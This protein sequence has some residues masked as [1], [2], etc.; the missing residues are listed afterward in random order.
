MVEFFKLLDYVLENNV[1]IVK[2]KYLALLR[3]LTVTPE[4]TDTDFINSLK[5][6][7]DIG[8]IVIGVCNGDIVCS[9]TIIIEP[10]IIHGGK[11]VGH[12]EDIVVL[13]KWRGKGLA[14][15]V[16]D[17]LKEYGFNNNCYKI[18]LDCDAKLETFYAKSKFSKKGIKMAI[19]K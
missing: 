2:H 1:S 10:K 19:Y 11:S 4:I 17:H 14:S 5:K 16:I 9:G 7:H 18:I 13:E 6:I 12:I 8:K 15:A 3:E